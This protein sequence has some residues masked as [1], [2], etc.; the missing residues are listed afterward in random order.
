MF[1]FYGKWKAIKYESSL[2]KLRSIE[3]K[4]IKNTVAGFKEEK[5]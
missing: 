1:L 4:Q 2:K 5:N 3:G